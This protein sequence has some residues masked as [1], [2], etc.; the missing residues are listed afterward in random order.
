VSSSWPLGAVDL[1][2][3][4]LEREI[5]F[6]EWFGLTRLSGDAGSAIL[7]AGGQP[8][9]RLKTTSE[10]RSRPRRTAGLYHFAIRGQS[11]GALTRAAWCWHQ[12]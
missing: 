6:Y 2:V 5:G 4:D 3:L 7:G 9:L 11:P 12:A 1:K 10:L 8:L